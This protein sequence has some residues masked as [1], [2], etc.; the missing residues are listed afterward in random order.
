VDPVLILSPHLDDAVLSCGQ[1]MAGRPDVVVATVFAGYPPAPFRVT[2]P[3]DEHCGFRHAADAI[4]TRR[5]EDITALS[6]LNAA[7]MHLP[8]CDVQYGQAFD[9]EAASSMVS[10][11]VAA[12]NPDY[13]LAPLGVLHP[14]HYRVTSLAIRTVSA[15]RLRFYADLPGS[16][17]DPESILYRHASI[18]AESKRHN[19]MLQRTFVGTGEAGLKLQACE[20]YRSQWP[21]IGNEG[22]GLGHNCVMTPERYWEWA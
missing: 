16:V 18:A 8:F 15:D 21:V 5:E 22:N 6:V 7:A 19:A 9:W 14:D 1:F 12:V 2:T 17:T 10:S 3:Y 13:V 4:K 11:I 20:Q